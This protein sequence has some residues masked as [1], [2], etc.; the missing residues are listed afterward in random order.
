MWLDLSVNGAL[1]IYT[2]HKIYRYYLYFM[3]DLHVHLPLS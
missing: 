3:I 2:K 1:T